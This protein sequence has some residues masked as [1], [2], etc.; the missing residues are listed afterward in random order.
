MPCKNQACRCTFGSRNNLT[1]QWNED[2]NN[3]SKSTKSKVM[4]YHNVFGS[5]TDDE[6][7]SV[8]TLSM[9]S[10]GDPTDAV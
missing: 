10:P 5:L 2:P 9:Y 3:A 7:S 1:A 6:Y 4:K 8:I